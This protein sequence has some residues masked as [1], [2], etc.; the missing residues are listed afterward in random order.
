[1]SVVLAT[2]IAVG[3][4]VAAVAAFLVLA[5][6]GL[7]MRPSTNRLIRQQLEAQWTDT[8]IDLLTRQ[9]LQQMRDTVRGEFR[10][11]R[12][13]PCDLIDGQVVPPQRPS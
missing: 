5:F 2:L 6:Y 12:T 10:T 3:V 4:V 1:M 7:I 11:A 13:E 9:T 8:Q